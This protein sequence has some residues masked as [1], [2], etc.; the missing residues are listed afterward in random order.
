MALTIKDVDVLQKYIAGVM[1]RANHHA[2]NVEAIALALAGAILWR[3]DSIDIKVME[4]GGDTKNVLWVTI[5]GTRYAFSYNHDDEKIEM[6][7]NNTHGPTIH[8]FDNSTPVGDIKE[9]FEEL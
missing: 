8:R 9:I 6:R 7:E 4:Q 2:G 5:S 1:D 3:K